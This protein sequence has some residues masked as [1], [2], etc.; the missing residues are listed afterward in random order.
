[1]VFWMCEKKNKATTN[2]IIKHLQT[3]VVMIVIDKL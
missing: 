3:V 1:M 2:F